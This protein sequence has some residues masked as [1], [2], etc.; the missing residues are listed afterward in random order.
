MM[1]KNDDTKNLEAVADEADKIDITAG[2]QEVKIDDELRMRIRIRIR[3][4]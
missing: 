3:I 2:T 1:T 4:R